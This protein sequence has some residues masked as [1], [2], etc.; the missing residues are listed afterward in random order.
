MNQAVKFKKSNLMKYGMYSLMLV[1]FILQAFILSEVLAES[2]QLVSP[3]QKPITVSVVDESLVPAIFKV[4]REDPIISWKY[5]GDSCSARGA[6]VCRE[7]DRQL[8]IQCAKAYLDCCQGGESCEF[9]QE[10][11]SCLSFQTEFE[12]HRW[13]YHTAPVF[14]VKKSDGSVVPQVFDL[15]MSDQPL[16][17]NEWKTKL[18]PNTKTHLYYGNRYSARGFDLSTLFKEDYPLMI[19]E[20]ERDLL[21]LKAKER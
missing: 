12:S 11:K 16:S 13:G 17:L 3:E 1:A 20:G 2:V 21:E 5:L 14:M 4:M 8:G 6:R 7:L 10:R 18:N 19:E 15:G 9:A